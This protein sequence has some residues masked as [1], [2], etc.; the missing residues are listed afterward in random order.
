MSQP[1][2]QKFLK[3]KISGEVHEFD[4]AH[5]LALTSN[6]RQDY[7][8][9]L[10]DHAYASAILADV[11]HERLRLKVLVPRMYSKAYLAYKT[12]PHNFAAKFNPDVKKVTDAEAEAAANLDENYTKLQDMLVDLDA[13]HASLENLVKQLEMKARILDECGANQRTAW[14]SKLEGGGH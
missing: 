8:S 9:L 5:M 11:R 3:I 6:P 12:S 7:Q 10:Q 14:H 2:P 13:S 1:R 4:T